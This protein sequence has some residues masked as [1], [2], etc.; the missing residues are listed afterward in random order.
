MFDR[1]ARLALVVT[2]VTLAVC[3]VG[4]RF[5]AR[6]AEAYFAK[7][8]VELRQPLTN[9]PKQLGAWRHHGQDI[10]LTA[11][12]EESLGTTDYLDR[13]YEREA[14]DGDTTAVLV[15]V[16]YYTGLIDAVP[17]VADRCL[18]AGGWA[19]AGL[20]RNIDLPIDRSGWRPDPGP[21]NRTTNQPYPLVTI[22]HHITGKPLTVRM[23]IVTDGFKLRTTEF[24][25]AA[26][27]NARIYAGY[28]FIANGQTTPTPEGVRAFAFNLQTKYAYYAKI[29]FTMSVPVAMTADE[30]AEVVAD[31]AGHLLPQLMLCLPDWSEIE[32]ESAEPAA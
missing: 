8:P 4:F 21:V 7:R 12:I 1:Q 30:F 17:H 16:P 22:R 14:E 23:P 25:D 13:V 27:P 2:A 15:H 10:T 24:L 11:E 31:L 3:G 32:S 28:F 6:A 26:D 29:Q 9:I 5:A 18:Q 20:P 19:Q